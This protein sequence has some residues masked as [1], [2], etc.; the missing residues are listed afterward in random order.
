MTL[1]VKICGLTQLAQAQAIAEMGV[2][3]LGFMA[4]PSS[5]RFL[6]R[7]QMQALVANLPRTVDTVGV[8]MD[9]PL[10]TIVAYVEQVGLTAVQLHGQESPQTCADLMA[11]LPSSIQLI[12]AFRL[13]NPAEL[14]AIS[15]YTAV[16]DRILI[17]AYHPTLAGGTG[18]TVNRIWLQDFPFPLPWL[19]AGGLKPETVAQALQQVN[20]DG[21]DL[22]S[23][24]EISPGIKDLA[25]VRQL[26]DR[27]AQR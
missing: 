26:M 18:Q 4:V 14:T 1:Y 25:K 24:V 6:P 3:A 27:V 20:P 9:Q 16:V 23:G 15:A 5:P 11:R 17:D 8:F 13:Q 21:I 7:D 10:D 2:S 12:K 19:L 22:S